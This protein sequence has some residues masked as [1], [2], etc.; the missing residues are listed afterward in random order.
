M[1]SVSSRIPKKI[2]NG[3]SLQPVLP[4]IPDKLPTEK[5]DKSKFVTFEL[6]T[7]VDQPETAMKYKKS[8]RKFEEGTAQQWIDL[9]QDLKEIWRQNGISEGSDQAATVR[10]L[11]KG[12]ST[13]S[14]EAALEERRGLNE[15]GEELPIS[16][17]NVKDALE[18]VSSTVFP[19]RALEI[20]K[21]W[22]NRKMYKPVE[23][24]A[25]QTAAAITRLNNSLPVLPGGSLSSKFTDNQIVELF[26][27]S[28]PPTWRQIR[29]GRVHS[30][31]GH[32]KSVD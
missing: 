10:S 26:E 28:L 15:A 20:Q 6:K 8:V 11:I 16:E 17:E 18:A 29:F 3:G 24:T 30:Y 23:L 2:R 25:R 14:F 9:L 5:E 7:Q 32:Q 13:T 31:I 19:H 12:E 21:L 22:M 1:L 27:W 4:L